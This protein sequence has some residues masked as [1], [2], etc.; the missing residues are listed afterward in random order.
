MMIFRL[1]LS[2]VLL[3]C[4]ACGK[5]GPLI[6]P[7]LYAPPPVSVLHV[8]QQGEAFRISWRAPELERRGEGNSPPAGFRIYRR[9]A[10]S[11]GDEC[12][13]CGVEEL[14]IRTVELK[15]PRDVERVGNLFVV[16]D[17]DVRIGKSYL[18]QVTPFEESGVES[19]DSVR[20]KRK[21]VQPPPAPTVRIGD[22]PAGI[23]LEWPS[24]QVTVGTLAGY[25]IYRLRS[26]ERFAIRPLTPAPIM[27]NRYEDPRMEPAMVYRY[28]LR[29]VSR[30]DGETVESDPSP[31]LEGK[32]VLP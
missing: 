2:V 19:R 5:K 22:V 15:Y 12:S 17:G 29:A 11:P 31:P 4:L 23:M 9:E 21:M 16:V 1:F 26:D 3:L 32:F 13:V 25:N 10:Y 24:V 14:L 7:D 20:V 6:P 18:Y 8:I 30:I 27:E 28:Q